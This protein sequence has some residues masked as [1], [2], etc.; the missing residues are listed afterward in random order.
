MGD[1]FGLLQF[2]IFLGMLEI[3]DFLGCT[4]D[5]GPEPM[6]EEKMRVTRPLPPGMSP[7]RHRVRINHFRPILFLFHFVSN[8]P[9]LEDFSVHWH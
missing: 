6:Y 4:V 2:Q 1:I 8:C 9:E 3:I 7:C 5:A